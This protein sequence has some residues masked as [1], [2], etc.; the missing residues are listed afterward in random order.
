MT[1]K[2]FFRGNP[3]SFEE[4]FPNIEEIKI[5]GTEGSLGSGFS[6]GGKRVLNKKNLGGLEPCS[7]S[8]CEKGGYQLGDFISEM[9]HKK[10]TS[11]EDTIMCKGH[12]NMGRDQSRECLNGFSV[13]IEIKYKSPAL[14]NKEGN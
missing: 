8:V 5:E 2:Y 7:N 12:E 1:E 10:K 4:A 13:K 11:K 6:S 3:V 14:N 9:Y